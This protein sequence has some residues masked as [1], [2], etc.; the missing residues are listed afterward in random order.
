MSGTNRGG[1]PGNDNASVGCQ[2]RSALRRV[3]AENEAKGRA[4]LV[5]IMR[6]Q[7]DKAEAGDTPA[8]KFICDKAE[9]KQGSED[10]PLRHNHNVTVR[11]VGD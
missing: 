5:N 11:Y 6:A 7:V 1:Q 10:D 4:S 2:V 3:L 9:V 8:A